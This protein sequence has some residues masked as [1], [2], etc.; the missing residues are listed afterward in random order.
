MKSFQSGMT[1]QL[2]LAQRNDGTAT[3]S[4]AEWPDIARGALP[5]LRG[6][7]VSGILQSLEDRKGHAALFSLLTIGLASEARSTASPA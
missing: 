6:P 5:H 4:R 3:D 2:M 7:M 1:C